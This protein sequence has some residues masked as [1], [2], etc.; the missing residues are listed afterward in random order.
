MGGG[1]SYEAVFVAQS[2]Y[3]HTFLL[4][5]GLI[6]FEGSFLKD[7]LFGDL[8]TELSPLEP[9][10]GLLGTSELIQLKMWDNNHK[11]IHFSRNSL[12]LPLPAL[13][14]V[15][16]RRFGSTL[17]GPRFYSLKSLLSPAKV[18]LLPVICG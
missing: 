1:D 12:H 10:R 18:P 6:F 15:A 9:T 7:I 14:S 17:A 13:F 3:F 4:I 2:T 16:H 5:S 11:M 8:K